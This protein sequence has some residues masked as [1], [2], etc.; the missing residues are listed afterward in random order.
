[1]RGCRG[2]G[3]RRGNRRERKR[4]GREGMEEGVGEC[5]SSSRGLTCMLACISAGRLLPGVA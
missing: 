3:E 4:G 5:S 2:K 1:V